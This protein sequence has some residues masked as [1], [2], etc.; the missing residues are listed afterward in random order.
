MTSS[1]GGFCFSDD[2]ELRDTLS[3]VVATQLD[4][5]EWMVRPPGFEPGSVPWKAFSIVPTITIQFGCGV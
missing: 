4:K 5:L 3:K 2:C 1:S